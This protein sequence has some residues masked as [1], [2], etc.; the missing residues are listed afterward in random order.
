MSWRAGWP[1]QTPERTGEE[2][3][4][5]LGSLEIWVEKPG[6]EIL[7]ESLLGVQ[8]LSP[9][10]NEQFPGGGETEELDSWLIK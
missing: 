5:V 10:W 9:V 7:T 4:H 8:P 1:H 2:A 6:L 3:Q